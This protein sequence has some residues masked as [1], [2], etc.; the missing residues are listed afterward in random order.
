MMDNIRHVSSPLIES[1]DADE[2]TNDRAHSIIQAL[3]LTQVTFLVFAGGGI[4]WLLCTF[5]VQCSNSA[6][7][8]ENAI[9]L[10]L[11]CDFLLIM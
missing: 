2:Q 7:T 5:L 8:R 1:G 6:R 11:F 9:A 3:Q 4:C 10:F